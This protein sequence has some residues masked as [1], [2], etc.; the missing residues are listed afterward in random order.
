MLQPTSC[1]V[2]ITPPPI[3]HC[4]ADRPRRWSV[5]DVRIIALA[6]RYR[7]NR[8]RRLVAPIVA[9]GLLGLVSILFPQLLGDGKDIAQLAFADQIPFVLLPSLLVLKPLRPSFVW[10]AVCRRI[11]HAL[12]GAWSF[13]GWPSRPCLFMVLARDAARTG[14]GGWRRRRSGCNDAKTDLGGRA[15]QG[16]DRS[17]PL[18]HC[19]SVACS[20]PCD[21]GFA[22]DQ[23]RSIYD[24]RLTD[25]Q[26]E[27]R[28][29]L[30][31]PEK[32]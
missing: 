12:A 24:A 16:T 22:Y 15:D 7:P 31:E 4:V 28:Q 26:I 18:V 17:G 2:S 5:A 14:R 10:E 6:D 1:L 11:V 21:G 20:H 32:R 30:R 23:P 3:S 9:L 29:K 13:A 27:Q 8:W 19:A 25:E